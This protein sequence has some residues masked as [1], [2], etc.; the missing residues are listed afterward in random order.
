MKATCRA[1]LSIVSL[2]LFIPLAY[3]QEQ[4]QPDLKTAMDFVSGSLYTVGKLGSVNW[5]ENNSQGNV[6]VSFGSTIITDQW[7]DSDSGRKLDCYSTE[8]F[9]TQL[10]LLDPS[11]VTV[12]GNY[13][14]A[15]TTNGAAMVFDM[16][17]TNVNSIG[18]YCQD[19]PHKL[20]NALPMTTYILIRYNDADYAQRAAKALA[21]A[22]KLAGGKASAF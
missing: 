15:Y 11:H 4:S 22:I 8:E 6:K 5:R 21:Y 12:D 3:G 18:N 13:V 17:D 1:L 9:G 20:P 14:K 7:R 16:K 19:I 10:G 2:S